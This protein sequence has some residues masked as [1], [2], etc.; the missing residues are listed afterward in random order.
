MREVPAYSSTTYRDKKSDYCILIPVINEGKKIQ[1]QLQRMSEFSNIFDVIIADG[2]S[3]DG[4][5]EDEFLRSVNVAAKLV[6]TGPGKLSAQMRMA[7]DYAMNREYAGVIFMDG[8]NKDNPEAILRFEQ[9]LREG[10]DHVQGSRFVKGGKHENTPMSRYLAIR[11][12][13]AP[14]I[15][16]AARFRYTD[17][18]NGFR[19]YSRKFILDDRVSLFREIFSQYELH[20]YLAIQAAK[21]KFR[22]VEIP[23][24]RIY[25]ST[26]P[27]PTKI[28][29]MRGNW[30][31]MKTLFRA[32]LGQFDP[33]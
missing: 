18:T 30:L 13:H 32:C 28:G 29:G 33:K 17:T 8:N 10:F 15:S 26:G 24:E 20:Y 3:S 5:L 22:V 11:F 4:S 23:V 19:A 2:G 1:K 6:K 14:L 9:K 31:V 7:L 25:P 21:L 12:I 16:L 27:V